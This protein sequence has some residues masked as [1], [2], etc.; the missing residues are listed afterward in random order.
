MAWAGELPAHIRNSS[1]FP[2]LQELVELDERLLQLQILLAQALL[3][4][5]EG[6]LPPRELLLLRVEGLLDLQ[7]TAMHTVRTQQVGPA[8]A[9]PPYLEHLPPLLQQ[10]RRG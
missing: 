6:V 1:W 9:P 5:P 2:H 3:T 10:P 8:R 4:A 7:S